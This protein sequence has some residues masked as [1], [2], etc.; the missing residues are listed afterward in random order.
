MNFIDI[1]TMIGSWSFGEP[2]F[3][4]TKGLCAEMDRLNIRKAFTYHFLAAG[5]DPKVGNDA[6]VEEI[7]DYNN[8]IGTMVLTPLIKI[9]FGGKEAVKDFMMTNR[10]GAIR[11]FPIDHSYTLENWNMEEIFEITNECSVPIFFDMRQ[12]GGNM[13]EHF[14]DFYYLAKENPETPIVL[15]TVG[16]R[17]LR[18]IMKLLENC[19]NIYIDTSDFITY[20]GIE[21][22]VKHFGSKQILFGSRMPFIEGGVSIGRIIYSSIAETD[23]ENIAYKNAERLLKNNRFTM[24]GE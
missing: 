18:T 11:L 23:K 10:I 1:N 20:R 9:E 22:I 14:N 2:M 12:R 16:Y 6:L 21:D 24:K 8:I 19:P 3:K 4:D 7:K 5:Y 15:L 13:S 17:H